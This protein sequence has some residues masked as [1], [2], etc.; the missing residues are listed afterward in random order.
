M[1]KLLLLTTLCVVT[2]S[3]MSCEKDDNPNE[4]PVPQPVDNSYSYGTSIKLADG[5]AKTFIKHDAAGVPLE[6]GLAISENAVNTL[7]KTNADLILD[8]PASHLRMPFKF[9][10]LNYMHGGHG[11]NGIYNKDLFDLRF[12]TVANTVRES[13]TSNTD[14]RLT[15]FPEKDKIP[16]N[17]IFTGSA[18]LVGSIWTDTTSVEFK[19]QPFTATFVY[20]SLDGEMVFHEP[21]IAVEYLKK[22]E[23]KMFP[24]KRPLKYPTAASGFNYYPTEYWTRY[25]ETLK[26]YEV[27]LKRMIQK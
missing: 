6:I 26:Q 14:P 7:P 11:P 4:T 9:V 1:R 21:K 16:A 18:P 2:I 8:L 20:G 23:T 12:Y 17:Y 13:I 10:H 3:F 15:R 5:T 27:V 24:I 19:G 22:R 25:N